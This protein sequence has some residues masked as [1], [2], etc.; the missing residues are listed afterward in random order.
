MIW[1][2][3]LD[4]ADQEKVYWVEKSEYRKRK[5][6]TLH[7]TPLDVSETLDRLLFTN[8]EIG[9]AVMTSSHIKH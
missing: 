5:F 1:K 8:D 2:E 9:C 4:A 7:A 6:I 3:I